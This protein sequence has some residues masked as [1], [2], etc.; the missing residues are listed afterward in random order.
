MWTKGGR[1]GDSKMMSKE[2][3]DKICSHRVRSCVPRQ[4]S[5]MMSFFLRKKRKEARAAGRQESTRRESEGARARERER[6]RAQPSER[7]R[8]RK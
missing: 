7:Q 2:E 1:E 4:E 5:K 3:A 6:E 8:R